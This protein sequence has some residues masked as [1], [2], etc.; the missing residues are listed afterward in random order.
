VRE[1]KFRGKKIDN[2][3]W[4][5][6]YFYEECGNT[7]IIENKQKQKE[8][9]LFRN[10][11][12]KIDKDTVGQF[13]G[14]KDKNGGEIYEGDILEV[15]NGSINGIPWMDKKPYAVEYIINKG[16]RMC[17]FCWDEN[18]DNNM[19]STHWCKVIGNIHENPE[20]LKQ[21]A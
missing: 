9:E 16:F 18:G 13:T 6:G 20:L 15:C 14:L 2:K 12:Y 11:P 19:N 17:M 1:I 5:Y 8:S 4:V 3:K 10:S 21:E 7:Y